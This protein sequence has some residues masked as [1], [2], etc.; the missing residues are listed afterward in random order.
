MYYLKFSSDTQLSNTPERERNKILTKYFL[1]RNKI[2]KGKGMGFNVR[3]C[4]SDISASRKS[5]VMVANP[6]PSLQEAIYPN[7]FMQLFITKG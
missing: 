2:V 4:K 1:I 5:A 3:I 7:F 6:T